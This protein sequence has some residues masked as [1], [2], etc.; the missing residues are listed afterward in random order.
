[1]GEKGNLGDAAGL[2]G[3]DVSTA[4]DPG[5]VQRMSD[6]QRELTGMQRATDEFGRVIGAVAPG[7]D[8]DTPGPT[9]GS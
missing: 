7:S 9:P 8:D 3:A 5:M 1:M 4:A 2:A 6:A